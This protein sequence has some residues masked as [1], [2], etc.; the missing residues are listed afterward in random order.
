MDTENRREEKNRIKKV[1]LHRK[2]HDL[3]K[4]I[5]EEYEAEQER[6]E[7]EITPAQ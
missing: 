7:G 4:E 1:L 2:I 6:E 5:K 3:L